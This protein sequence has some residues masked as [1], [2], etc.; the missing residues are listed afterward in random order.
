MNSKI[1][2][3]IND[4]ILLSV[5][6]NKYHV[7]LSLKIFDY[8]Y[9]LDNNLF[10]KI[11]RHNNIKIIEHV[12]RYGIN[13]QHS[14]KNTRAVHWICKYGRASHVKILIEKKIYLE[15]KTEN[16]IRPIHIA[17]RYNNYKII[18]LLVDNNVS[19]NVADKYGNRP[20]HF[21]CRF[22]N[23]KILKYIV[24]KGADINVRNN[25]NI[26]PLH[27]ACKIGDFQMAKYLIDSGVN[28][29]CQDDMYLRPIHYVSYYECGLEENY[30]KIA[31][32]LIQK[33]VELKKENKSE[34]TPV[35]WASRNGKLKII[36][37]LSSHVDL[38]LCDKKNSQAIHVAC[39]FGHSSVVQYLVDKGVD[40]ETKNNLGDT[41][42]HF[43][44]YFNYTSI[45]KILIKKRINLEEKDKL[46]KLPIHIAC[47]KSNWDIV[48]LLINGYDGVF[49]Q[50]TKTRSKVNLNILDNEGKRPIDYID[51]KTELYDF[52]NHKMK[53]EELVLFEKVISRLCDISF[54]F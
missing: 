29:E 11:I 22:G 38:N 30:A 35:H 52:I 28:Y 9:L 19:L 5:K 34:W 15:H 10:L 2:K 46:G 14:N 40:L 13:M 26:T 44:C 7:L 47:T 25:K 31:D 12:L 6:E 1:I 37:I 50:Y 4:V 42:I 51:K 53:N 8:K 18:K 16:D 45:V 49:I 3:R 17:C 36:K 27:M 20:I 33:G 39:K 48:E 54:I 43:A 24:L 23:I 41:P 32:L 21:V